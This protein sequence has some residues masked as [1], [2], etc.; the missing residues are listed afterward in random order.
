MEQVA[1]KCV[2]FFYCS[3]YKIGVVI[4]LLSARLM[5]EVALGLVGT[6]VLWG[7]NKPWAG[8]AF[9]SK[10]VA[11]GKEHYNKALKTSGHLPCIQRYPVST[12]QCMYKYSQHILEFSTSVNFKSD[13]HYLV[14]NKQ[15]MPQKGV[16]WNPG[17]NISKTLLGTMVPPIDHT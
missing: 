17:G 12:G 4:K 11:Q 15:Q 2:F 3:F 14:L 9:R 8:S 6:E 16:T 13:D 1:L 5:Y 7:L 10:T